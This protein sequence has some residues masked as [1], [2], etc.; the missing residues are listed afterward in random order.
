M[1]RAFME[2]AECDGARPRLVQADGRSLP[3]PDAIFDAIMLIQIFGGMRGWRRLVT[4]VRRVV[5]RP[6]GTLVIGRSVTPSDVSM[7]E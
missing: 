1:L 2:R 5:L 6:A 4:E 3:F 7:P